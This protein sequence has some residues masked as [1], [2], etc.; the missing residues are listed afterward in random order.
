MFSIVQNTLVHYLNK[1]S[2]KLYKILLFY[3]NVMDGGL[4]L[5]EITYLLPRDLQ[6]AR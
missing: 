4:R 5:R 3:S 1:S 6:V 2:Q